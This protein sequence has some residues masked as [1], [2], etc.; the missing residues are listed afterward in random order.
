MSSVYD[1]E[2][3]VSYQPSVMLILLL[4][5]IVDTCVNK[6]NTVNIHILVL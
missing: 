5:S 6:M 4:L 2:I 3:T 1:N